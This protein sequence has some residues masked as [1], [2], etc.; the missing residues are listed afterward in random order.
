MASSC[1]NTSNNGAALIFGALV[2]TQSGQGLSMAV[3][4]TNGN[5]VGGT[6]TYN[7]LLTPQGVMGQI[8]NGT[9]SCTV[10]GQAS[11]AGTFNVDAITMQQTGFTGVFT[12]KDQFCTYNGYFGG[13]KDVL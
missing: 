3:N 4:F 8:A 7:G 10:G 12:G 1:Q 9:F 11:N 5:G 6:C 2:V 13:V